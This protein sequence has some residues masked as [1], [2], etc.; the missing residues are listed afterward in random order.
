MILK[1]SRA[2]CKINKHKLENCIRQEY[3]T[4]SILLLDFDTFGLITNEYK[5]DRLKQNF[6]DQSKPNQIVLVLC[7]EHKKLQDNMHVQHARASGI[8]L[9]LDNQIRVFAVFFNYFVVV[10]RQYKY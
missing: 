9:L 1:P 4:F 8:I 10:K 5:T 6:E 2:L 7:D 3:D